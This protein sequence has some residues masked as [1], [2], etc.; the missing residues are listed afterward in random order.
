[1]V[2]VW[3]LRGLGVGAVGGRIGI[4]AVSLPTPPVPRV[5]MGGARLSMCRVIWG[6]VGV[7]AVARPTPLA[8][9]VVVGG[10]RM[11]LRWVVCAI[12]TVAVAMP[13]F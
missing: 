11:G 10:A 2:A 8:P 4:D 9:R 13:A 3:T 5:A 6:W 12:T 7:I 1:M